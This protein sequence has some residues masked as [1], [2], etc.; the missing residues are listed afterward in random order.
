MK[1][2]Q[3]TLFARPVVFY[4][5]SP[6]SDGTIWFA[7]LFETRAEDVRNSGLYDL[8]LHYGFMN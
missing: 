1:G 4:N 5:V 3:T 6:R 8:G 7:Q 2:S